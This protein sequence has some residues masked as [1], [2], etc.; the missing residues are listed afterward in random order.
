RHARRKVPGLV[1]FDTLVK[2]VQHELNIGCTNKAVI[3]GLESFVYRWQ[4]DALAKGASPEE[5]AR[6]QAIVQSLSAYSTSDASQRAQML[7][8]VLQQLNA[9]LAGQP[10]RPAS[11]DLPAEIQLAS[12]PAPAPIPAVPAD[13]SPSQ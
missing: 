9:P 7:S 4:S 12:A 6:V 8:T 1:N 11:L 5:R 13:S 2:I 10:D 3:S